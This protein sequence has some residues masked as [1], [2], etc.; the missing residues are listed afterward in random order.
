MFSPHRHLRT[1]PF[2]LLP[3]EALN[4]YQLPT[5]G[6]TGPIS[7]TPYANSGAS[8]AQTYPILFCDYAP[9]PSV[10]SKGSTAGSGIVWAIEENQNKDNNPQTQGTNPQDCAGHLFNGNPGALH[11]FCAA[12]SGTPC[13][14]ALY[15]LYSSRPPLKSATI[16]SVHG[17][18]TPTIF[19]G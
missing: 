6:A 9:T 17:F 7:Q 8:N 11:A 13:P 4:A 1:I 14:S 2:C 18:P 3:H 19:E 16:G 12:Q 15:E 10:S 5:M